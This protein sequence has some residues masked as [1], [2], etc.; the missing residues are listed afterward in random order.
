MKIKS[1]ETPKQGITILK[2]TP[3]QSIR[4]HK[5]SMTCHIA[6]K[7]LKIMDLSK[8]GLTDILHM[9]RKGKVTIKPYTKV[10]E[11]AGKAYY[12]IF[13]PEHLVWYFNFTEYKQFP[14]IKTLPTFY[15][16]T[17]LSFNKCKQIETPDSLHN[18]LS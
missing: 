7:M 3:N 17:V 5:S 10:L 13:G 12:N 15:Q 1:C 8:T 14:L 9:P 11:K 16:S 4:S 2:S 18:L 6:S